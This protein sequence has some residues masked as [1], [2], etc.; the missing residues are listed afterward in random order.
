MAAMAFSTTGLM[1]SLA[2]RALDDR[3]SLSVCATDWPRPVYAAAASRWNWSCR[4]VSCSSSCWWRRS[5]CSMSACNCVTTWGSASAW[6]CRAAKVW[7]RFSAAM[8]AAEKGRSAPAVCC[9]SARATSV[10]SRRAMADMRPSM[11]ELATPATEVPKEMPRP[12]MGAA[13]APRMAPRSA[14]PSSANTAPLKVTTMPRKVP[15]M[16]SMTSRPMR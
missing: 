4:A 9:S 11:A 10:R 8:K 15:S 12:L 3:L 6:R 5:T 13:S 14:E 1:L 16:P 7:S 2:T